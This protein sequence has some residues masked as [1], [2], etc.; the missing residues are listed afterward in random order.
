MK[1]KNV[2]MYLLKW[3]AVIL[4]VGITIFSAFVSYF[5]FERDEK[6]AQTATNQS[7]G[8]V[9]DIISGKNSKLELIT[10]DLLSNQAKVDSMHH[11]FDMNSED[12]LNYSLHAETST[13][14]NYLPLRLR[15]IYYDDESVQ[16]IA[17][18]LE[19]EKQV[20][21]SDLTNKNGYLV[22]AVP[23]EENGIRLQ[24]NL[25]NPATL[26][27]MGDFYLTL[28]P[29]EFKETLSTYGE[30]L[31]VSLYILTEQGNL[32]F[33]Y[34]MDKNDQ[35]KETLDAQ[36]PNGI[37][38]TLSEL[39]KKYIVKHVTL[40]NG[41]QV[42][43]LISNQNV[44]YSMQSSLIFLWVGVFLLNL[45]LIS[46]LYKI[47]SKYNRQ[48][49][50]ILYSIQDVSNGE[51]AARIDEG[52][53]EGELYAISHGINAM[54]D[55]INQYITDIYELEIAQKDANMRALQSQINPHFLYNTLEYIRMYAVSLEADE[56]SE[57][58]YAFAA[59][60]RNNISQEKTTTVAAELDFCEKY[61][62][63]YQMRYPDRLAYSFS[64]AQ[65][66]RDVR[67]PKFIIQP[68]LENYFVHGVDYTRIDNAGS[69]K[70]FLEEEMV[71]I[72]VKD[73]G[74]GMSPEKLV[75]LEEDLLKDNSLEEG[76]SI[77]IKNVNER[78]RGF[79]GSLYRMRIMQNETGGVT[80][81]IRFP[82]KKERSES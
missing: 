79:F 68:L 51:L 22:D 52:S 17:I 25:L 9:A 40:A 24:K 66:V 20:L 11:F 62:Y 78:M 21:Y 61:F 63:L 30:D 47:F 55:S 80:I 65:E 29:D 15:E 71:V 46:A 82:L 77:G 6:I 13:E 70:A 37:D 72:I 31:P 36:L 54:L 33:N 64:V 8:H 32:V 1:K 42:I 39:N 16:S 81:E 2:F 50:G 56:L 75:E 76:K 43:T 19:D 27:K 23:K 44:W 59:L 69:I 28:R 53:K 73:N 5:I 3:Y 49:K 38:K 35:S 48:V 18:S 45:L 67:I 58:V 10:R 12:Y 7:A 4:I 60:L 57:V 34:Q 14:Y 26:E 41:Y 74:M